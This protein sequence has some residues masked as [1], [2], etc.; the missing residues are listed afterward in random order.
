MYNMISI[1]NIALAASF[2]ATTAQAQIPEGYYDSL[3]GKKG[4][5]LKTAI[6]N[7][8]KDADVLSYGSGSGSTWSGFYKT[9]R[10]DDNSVVDRYSNDTRYFTST[11]SAVSGMNIEHSFPKSWWGGSKNQAYQDLYN[12]MPCEQK[13]NSSKSNYPMG[14]VTNVKTTNGCTTIGT[15]SNGYQLWEPADKWKG[16]FARGYMYMATTYQNL[17]WSGTQAL[18]ILENNTYPTL[19][20]W[21]YTLYMEWAEADPVDELELKRNEAV[22]QIQGNRNPYVDFPNLMH[23][24]WGDSVGYD[25]DPATSYCPARD[26]Y[27]TD[28][29]DPDTPSEGEQTLVEL[30]LLASDGGFT[31]EDDT[32]VGFDVWTQNST[33]GWTGTAYKNKKRYAADSYL[34]SPEIDL[35][36]YTE[37]KLC[38]DHIV[39]YCTTPSDYLSVEVRCE[40]TAT[41]LDGFTWPAGNS[42]TKK[43]SGF[44][45]LSAF[46]GKKIQVAFRYTS[47]GTSADTPTW[48]V[49]TFTVTG[50]KGNASSIEA[51]P[52]EAAAPTAVYDL[53][54]RRVSPDSHKKGIVIVNGRKY[55]R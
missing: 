45:D 2:F 30:D 50:R 1:R 14:K 36:A 4:A 6:Y 15:G 35:T 33:Y 55:S 16:D 17:S 18:E 51:V 23:Y 49:Q 12:L 21:A 52:A 44:I 38:F 43:N 40:G 48:E 31:T 37:P 53:G 42:W 34:V 28:P 19:Q 54:G 41:K 22:S 24:V 39:N 10:L 7:V 29:T 8:V 11:T 5:A 47:G 13:I 20:E 46:A 26:G 9:D 3:K 25:F 27:N 32:S